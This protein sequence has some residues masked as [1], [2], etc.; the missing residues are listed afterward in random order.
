[1]RL[2]ASFVLFVLFASIA[3]TSL[4]QISDEERIAQASDVV[5]G[6]VLS[7]SHRDMVSR[8]RKQDI[9]ERIYH[10]QMIVTKV[11]KGRNFILGAPAAFYYRRAID[12]PRNWEEKGQPS[13][14]KIKNIVKAYLAFDE[15]THSFWLIE[16]KG[17]DLLLSF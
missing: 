14:I 16:P 3:Q 17:F 11:D 4:A 7:T 1:M 6:F 13:T 2:G 12:C 15:M 10:V 9:I 5:T 8:V